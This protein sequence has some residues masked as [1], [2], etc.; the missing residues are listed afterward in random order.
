[1]LKKANHAAHGI[2]KLTAWFFSQRNCIADEHVGRN[3]PINCK[4]QRLQT[5]MGKDKQGNLW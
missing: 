2:G 4:G 1:M 5:S 3:R